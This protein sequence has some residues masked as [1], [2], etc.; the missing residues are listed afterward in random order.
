L[1]VA[2]AV[3]QADGND[4]LPPLEKPYLKTNGRLKVYQLKKYLA[5]KLSASCDIELLCR[6][7]VLGAELSLHFITKTRWVDGS[8]DLLL[9]YRMARAD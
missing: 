4:P 5:K 6:G 2:P 7:D 1:P 9:N 8:H 3:E